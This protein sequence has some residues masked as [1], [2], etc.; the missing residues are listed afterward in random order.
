MNEWRAGKW[1]DLGTSTYLWGQ[2]LSFLGIRDITPASFTCPKFQPTMPIRFVLPTKMMPAS[3]WTYS[4]LSELLFMK[5]PS[6]VW[7]KNQISGTRTLQRTMKTSPPLIPEDWPRSRSRSDLQHFPQ[8][9]LRKEALGCN[10]FNSYCRNY[11]L[12]REA[13]MIWESD[14]ETPGVRYFL[15]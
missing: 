12:E 4:S 6:A 15:L 7:Y 1:T 2:L 13:G 8:P 11:E 5:T 10:A 9:P 14:N 3:S